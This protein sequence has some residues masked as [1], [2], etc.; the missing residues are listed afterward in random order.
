LPKKGKVI[1]Q[2]RVKDF[3]HWRPFFVNDAQRQRKAGFTNW[4]LCRNIDDPKDLVIVFDCNDL[5]KA[6]EVYSD[7]AVGK[8]IEKAGVVGDTKFLLVEELESQN[9]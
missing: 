3:D 8:I 2:H 1:V 4:H 9:L 7:P 5:D 6:R